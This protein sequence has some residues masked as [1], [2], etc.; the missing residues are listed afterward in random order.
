MPASIV[1]VHFPY[2]TTIIIPKNSIIAILRQTIW[3]TGFKYGT[4]NLLEDQ[5]NLTKF[6]GTKIRSKMAELQKF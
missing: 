6:Q 1:V 2:Y 4:Q 3:S 5:Y